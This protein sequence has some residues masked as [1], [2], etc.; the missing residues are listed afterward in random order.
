MEEKKEEIQQEEKK[1]EKKDENKEEENK[2]EEEEYVFQFNKSGEVNIL[3]TKFLEGIQMLSKNQCFKELILA[4]VKLLSG[5]TELKSLDELH[6]A[7]KPISEKCSNSVEELSNVVRSLTIFFQGCTRRNLMLDSLM[8]DLKQ[9][10]LKA[11]KDLTPSF[12]I[13]EEI[14]ESFNLRCKYG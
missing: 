7:L 8:K 9:L 12:V 3:E 14:D 1:E 2:E 5:E 11:N 4:S 13:T 6:E 10:F